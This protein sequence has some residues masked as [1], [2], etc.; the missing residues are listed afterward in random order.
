MQT[1]LTLLHHRWCDGHQLLLIFILG[2]LLI[3]VL[4]C[5]PRSVTVIS[6]VIVLGSSIIVLRFG[7]S[8]PVICGGSI[9]VMT[10]LLYLVAIVVSIVILLVIVRATSVVV[11]ASI[12]V[13]SSIL[14]V[15]FVIVTAAVI[16]VLVPVLVVSILVIVTG[17]VVLPI[18]FGL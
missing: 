11:V 13:A 5:V 12:V 15:V 16:I 17:S 10:T 7:L 3:L 14:V 2:S 18:P 4:S 1:R 8:A 9:A 6:S